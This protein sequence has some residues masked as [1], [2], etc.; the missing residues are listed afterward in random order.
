MNGV[1]VILAHRGAV[2][3]RRNLRRHAGAVNAS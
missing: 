3:L 1:L 2:A